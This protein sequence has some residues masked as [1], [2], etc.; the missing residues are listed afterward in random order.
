LTGPLLFI[1]KSHENSCRSFRYQ[2][3]LFV[4][5]HPF[6]R[7]DYDIMGGGLY[8]SHKKVRAGAKIISKGNFK[9]AGQ[10][11]LHSRT[12]L[13]ARPKKRECLNKKPGTDFFIFMFFSSRPTG[14]GVF[15]L[16]RRG[17]SLS[18]TPL[19]RRPL[20]CSFFGQG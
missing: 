7:P 16:S 19:S 8:S 11:T 5:G 15:S 13:A 2:R 3:G 17:S 6:D 18:R 12:F 1:K 20:L 9:A 4:F 14:R 10:K